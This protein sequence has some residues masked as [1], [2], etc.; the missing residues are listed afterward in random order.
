ML[1]RH[2]HVSPAHWSK[3]FVEH[4]RTVHFVLIAVS[5][6]LIWILSKTN[7]SA[8]SQI[9]QIV[10]LKKDWPPSWLYIAGVDLHKGKNVLL[11][12]A[13][14]GVS[15]E[16][17][18]SLRREGLVGVVGSIQGPKSHE[19]LRFNLPE[20]NWYEDGDGSNWSLSHFPATLSSFREWWDDL[21]KSHR[22]YFPYHL[23]KT[24]HVYRA[25]TRGDHAWHKVGELILNP[26]TITQTSSA[27][28]SPAMEVFQLNLEKGEPFTYEDYKKEKVDDKEWEYIADA[29]D[30]QRQ[31]RLSVCMLNRVDLDQ[32]V[33]ISGLHF[34]AEHGKDNPNLVPLS[35]GPFEKS[36]HALSE[37]S[38]GLE[39]E[40][41]EDIEK[42]VA[43]RLS[44]SPGEYEAFGMKFPI[45]QI[46]TWG[47]VMLLGIQL[48]FFLYLRRLTA[49][50][51][52]ADPGWDV[53]WICLDRSFMAQ[54]VQF[55]TVV[56]LPLIAMLLLC[57]HALSHL[58]AVYRIPGSPHLLPVREWGGVILAQIALFLLVILTALLGVL[59]WAHRP[60]IKEASKKQCPVQ[61][62][63]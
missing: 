6:G 60:Q 34:E 40:P 50:L 33:L 49:K 24:G 21:Q 8:L 54:V 52:P 22:I 14:G 46:T 58:T 19:T 62:F 20:K 10:L 39:V 25:G 48:Y 53:P 16:F 35:P 4:L 29:K 26:V 1:R 55:A 17:G 44:K 47:T 56:I 7:A 36:F 23:C 41:L 63:E 31:F 12:D 32:E 3:D 30:G 42:D 9:R 5:V 11:R 15:R 59:S 57:S 61:L 13:S 37:E 27:D 43:E 51:D 2:A 45:A 28:S 18:P 38:S